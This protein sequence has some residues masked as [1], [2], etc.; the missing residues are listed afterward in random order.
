MSIYSLRASIYSSVLPLTDCNL[1]LLL[2]PL[3]RLLLLLDR[4]GPRQPRMWLE[5][6]VQDLDVAFGDHLPYLKRARG[7][8]VNVGGRIGGTNPERNPES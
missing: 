6:L 3:C 4:V 8:R 1:R 2:L 5:V 7:G